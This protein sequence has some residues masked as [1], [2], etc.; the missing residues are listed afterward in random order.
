MKNSGSA[1]SLTALVPNELSD[2][3]VDYNH[4]IIC[5]ENNDLILHSIET[6]KCICAFYFHE[7]CLQ[8]WLRKHNNE[9]PLCRKC[10]DFYEVLRKPIRPAN[11]DNSLNKTILVIICAIITAGIIVW[12][13]IDE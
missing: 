8:I 11:V 9:C 4:C 1:T 6:K 13:I 12:K 10:P 3:H 7:K 2:K 5:L